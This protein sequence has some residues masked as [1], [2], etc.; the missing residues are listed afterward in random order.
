M[1]RFRVAGDETTGRAPDYHV[2]TDDACGRILGLPS[3]DYA[4]SSI[5][6]RPR[7]ADFGIGAKPHGNSL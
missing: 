7:P 2:A 1:A 4:G 3:E 5:G 6:P